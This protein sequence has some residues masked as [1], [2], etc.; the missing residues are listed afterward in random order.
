MD[1]FEL[2]VK[3]TIRQFKL[4]KP[5]EKIGVAV[6]GGKDSTTLL[7]LL[8]KFY[9][10]DVTGIAIDEGIEGYR[11][12][13]LEDLKKFCDEFK[14]RYEIYSFK[15]LY[16]VTVDGIKGKMGSCMACGVLRRASLNSAARDFDKIATGHNLDD[17]CQSIVMNLLKGNLF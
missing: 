15:E 7:Y 6:S 1:R 13:T 11:E 8:H 4:I 16:G 3:D 12:S 2:H 17:E 5:G 10:A 9:G 14:I